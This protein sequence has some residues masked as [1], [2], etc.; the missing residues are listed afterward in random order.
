MFFC[1]CRNTYYSS[2]KLLLHSWCQR[3][4]AEYMEASLVRAGARFTMDLQP[5]KSQDLLAGVRE[6]LASMLLKWNDDLN[7]VVVGFTDE[8]LVTNQVGCCAC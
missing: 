4:A 5:D 8:R 6:Q 7:G 2:Q 3:I 1:V